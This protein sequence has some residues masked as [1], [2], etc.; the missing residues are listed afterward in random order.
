VQSF[1]RLTHWATNYIAALLALHGMSADQCSE[2]FASL[3]Q[4]VV[5][6]V[7]INRAELSVAIDAPSGSS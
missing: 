1:G 5:S 2:E 7:V 6:I 4:L 3:Y